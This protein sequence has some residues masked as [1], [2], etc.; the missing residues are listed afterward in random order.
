MGLLLE[1]VVVLGEALEG[2]FAVEVAIELAELTT[3]LLEV[4][5]L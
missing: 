3:M 2:E 4:E 5:E 1:P